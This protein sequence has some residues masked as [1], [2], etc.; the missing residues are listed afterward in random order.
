MV[1]APF[2]ITA[3]NVNLADSSPYTIHT[4]RA[5]TNIIRVPVRLE[6][7]KDEGTAYTLS[8][9][10]EN[11]LDKRSIE[12]RQDTVD[13][14]AAGYHGGAFVV[15][16]SCTNRNETRPFFWVPAKGFLDQTQAEKRLALPVLSGAWFRPGQEVTFRLRVT[17]TIASGTGSLQ[18]RLYYEE[19][20]LGGF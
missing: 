1:I 5:D 13:T 8:N 2:T 18:G 14:L 16:E 10:S 4:F 17:C 12:R 3:T 20:P 11:T 9:I 7:Q 15:V 6:L 19:F